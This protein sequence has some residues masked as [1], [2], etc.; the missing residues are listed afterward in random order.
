MR[1]CSSSPARASD[2]AA[3]A[4]A[5]P[6]AAAN[7]ATSN[8]HTKARP[9]AALRRSSRMHRPPISGIIHAMCAPM[10][11]RLLTVLALALGFA[12]LCSQTALY[13]RFQGWLEDAQQRLFAEPLAFEHA[14]VFDVDE[15]SMQRLE[16]RVG[17]WPYPRDVYART[18]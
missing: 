7:A 15:E 4:C 11:I 2:P 3:C 6:G 17:A 18:A 12:S 14:V 1:A 5:A 16:G 13:S 8:A 9:S 10:P